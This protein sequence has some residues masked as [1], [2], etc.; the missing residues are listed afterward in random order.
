VS[1]SDRVRAGF[2]KRA[3]AYESHAA[4]QRAIAWR[5]AHLCRDLS[6]PPGPAAD[7]G[8]G[9]GLFARALSE[10]RCGWLGRRGLLQLDLCPPLLE[11]NPGAR[12]WGGRLWDLE[13]GLPPELAGAGL[14]S[15][16][17][18]LQWLSRPARHLEHWCGRLAPAG[19][20]VLA[21]PTAAS[22]PEWHRAAERAGV[23]FRGLAL[24]EARALEAVA[25]R[26]LRV[27]RLQR[28]RFSRREGGGRRFLRGLQA[29]GAAASPHP[30]LTVTQLRRLL[31]H[32]PDDEPITWE[33]LL[34]IAQRPVGLPE[35]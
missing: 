7:L 2:S 8:A 34:L 27:H 13:R 23:P 3:P 4:L 32:W 16:S 30:P 5:L 18:A 22:F 15:S 28:L 12:R 14:L 25:R 29:I 10:Q 24:P 6:L 33:V 31:Q 26:W 20:L 35:A 17:F 21:V 11:R 9:S 1:F 19:W